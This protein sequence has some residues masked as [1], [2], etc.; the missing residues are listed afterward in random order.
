MKP[1][2]T[3]SGSSSL[4]QAAPKRQL[5]VFDSVC[6]IVGIII[7]AGI[8]ETSPKIAAI[9]PNV[10]WLIGIWAL[11]GMLSL[12][13]ALCYAELATSYPD[14]GGDYVFLSR[15]YGRWVGFLF[16]WCELWIVRPGNIGMMAFVFARYA[17]VMFPVRPGLGLSEGLQTSLSLLLYAAAAVAVLTFINVLGVRQGKWTQNLLTSSKV[18][19]LL[20]IVVVGLV[21]G[22]AEPLQKVA[23]NAGTLDL[24]LAMILVLFTYGGW[25]E[26]AYVGAEV[27]NPSK[28]IL[29]AL[30]LGTLAVTSIYVVVNLAFVYGLGFQHVQNTNT[31]ATDLLNAAVGP[32]AEKLI[33]VII[34]V[35]ALGAVNGQIFTGARVYYAMGRDHALFRTLGR[36]DAKHDTPFRSLVLQGVVAVGLVLGFGWYA[37]GFDNLLKFTTPIF[38]TFFLMVGVSLFVLRFRQPHL[39]RPYRVLLYPLVPV[40]FCGSCLFMLWS[41]VTWAIDNQTYEAI[42]AIGLLVVGGLVGLVAIW[43]ERRGRVKPPPSE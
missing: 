2:A 11:G 25:N 10:G 19:A 1:V 35:S 24:R 29:R 41:S 4:Q 36:W 12:L 27:K 3:P 43:I 23:A 42:W 14:S 22:A 28:N 21:Y 20:A 6:I 7:G 16:A 8:F 9:V 40:I 39:E 17:D 13:G 37:D 38:W 33:A 32:F 30:L 26:M 5:T 18:L 34:C 31:V 15:A